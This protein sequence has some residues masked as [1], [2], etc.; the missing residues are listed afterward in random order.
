M[1]KKKLRFCRQDSLRL[2]CAAD[3]M[4]DLAAAYENTLADLR[5]AQRGLKDIAAWA[6]S[7]ED[8]AG[9]HM[10]AVDTLSLISEA[11]K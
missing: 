11:N 8:H 4:R 1:D 9:I 3:R 10:R 7:H 6:K 5:I 2:E